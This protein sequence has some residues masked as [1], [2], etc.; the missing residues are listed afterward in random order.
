M[1][2]TTVLALVESNPPLLILAAFLIASISW[3]FGAGWKHV[4]IRNAERRIWREAEMLFRARAEQ[5]RRDA[6]PA[7]ALP[8]HLA[9]ALGEFRVQASADLEADRRFLSELPVIPQP[10]PGRRGAR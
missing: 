4:C 8:P 1:N 3:L 10:K 5:E 7:P 6:E 9:A 2:T